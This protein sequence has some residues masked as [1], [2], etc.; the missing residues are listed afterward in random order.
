M[1]GLIFRQLEHEILREPSLVPAN[2]QVEVL[3]QDPIEFGE[4][5]IHQDLLASNEVNPAGDP[6]DGDDAGNIWNFRGAHSA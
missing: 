4:V 2:R 6:F 1:F 3:R 5:R